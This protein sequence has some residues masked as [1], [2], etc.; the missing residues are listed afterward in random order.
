MCSHCQ[1]RDFRPRTE[2]EQGTNTMLNMW[3]SIPYNLSV[4]QQ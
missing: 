3:G 4:V 1:I 2:E